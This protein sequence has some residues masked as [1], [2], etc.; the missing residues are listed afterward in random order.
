MKKILLIIAIVFLIFQM[1]VLATAIDIGSPAIN[2]ANTWY[3]NVATVVNKDNPANESGSIITVEIWTYSQLEDAEVATFYVVS[4][5][6]LSTRDTEYIGVV[7]AG[8]K[9]TFTVNLD[10]EAGDYLGMYWGASRQMEMDA[11]GYAGCWYIYSDQIP[12]TNVT[13]SSI[14]G[15]TLSLYGIGATEEEEDNA[16]F[17]GT[18]F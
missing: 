4:G 13:F 6:N 9:R 11:S 12:C 7:A 15:R 18:N 8:A 10:V 1:I 3:P 2:R 5:N 17:F 16:V 14:D